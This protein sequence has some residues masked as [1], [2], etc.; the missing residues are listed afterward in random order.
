MNARVT[1]PVSAVARTGPFVSVWPRVSARAMTRAS[2]ASC[3]QYCLQ[4]VSIVTFRVSHFCFC[5][6]GVSTTLCLKL[7]DL[8]IHMNAQN[9]LP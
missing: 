4:G 2:V 5:L 1:C 9:K 6:Q 7:E 3:S 8:P